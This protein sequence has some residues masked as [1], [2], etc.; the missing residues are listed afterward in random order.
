MS[1]DGAS[2][3]AAKRME[4]DHHSEEK[5]R[6]GPK[7][8]KRKK[9]KIVSRFFRENGLSSGYY[10]ERMLWRRKVTQGGLLGTNMNYNL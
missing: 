3:A 8:E 5:D 10:K 1:F 4:G 7:K 6:K 9:K 2:F